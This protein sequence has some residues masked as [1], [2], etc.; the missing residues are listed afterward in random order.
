MMILYI[1]HNVYIHD[2]FS[3]KYYNN[4]YNNFYNIFSD[5]CIN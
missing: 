5:M 3:E 1:D 4:F 2:V